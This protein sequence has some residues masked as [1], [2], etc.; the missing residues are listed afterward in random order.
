MIALIAL[1]LLPLPQTTDLTREQLI[2][3]VP[4]LGTHYEFQDRVRAVEAGGY[5]TQQACYRADVLDRTV[6]QARTTAEGGW[7]YVDTIN[8]ETKTRTVERHTL[9][10]YET[11][12]LQTLIGEVQLELARYE[13]RCR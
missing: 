9:T 11:T 12:L 7:V 10:Q 3:A 1:L 6:A 2:E 13:R 5:S 8:P 4:G